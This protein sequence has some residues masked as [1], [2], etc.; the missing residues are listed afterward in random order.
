VAGISPRLEFNDEYR[1]FLDLAAGNVAAAVADARAYDEE[2]S[3]AE[4]LI[5]LDRAKT[6]FF[7]NVSH[8]FRTPLTLVLGPVE[9][10][11]GD[12]AEPAT[13]RQR[14]R[15][16]IAQRNALRLQKLVNTLLDFSRIEAG[17]LQACYEPTDLASLTADL[18]SNFRSACDKA[19]LWLYV[20]CPHLTEPVY[21]DPDL[22]EKIVLNLLSNAFKFTFAGGIDVGLRQER[23]RCVLTVRDTGGGI[24]PDQTPFLFERFHRVAGVKGRTQEGTGIGLALVKELVRLHG[25]EVRAES[26]YGRGSVFTVSVPLGRAHL[27][28]ERIGT[29]SALTSTAL[30]AAPFVEEALRWLPNR[31][32]GDAPVV[33]LHFGLTDGTHASLSLQQKETGASRRPRILLVEDNADMRDY[34]ARLLAGRYEVEATWDGT[35]ALEVALKRPPDLILSDVM[36]PGLDGFGLLRAVRS[37]SRTAETPFLLLS[38]RAGEE[39]RVEGLEAGA[40]DYLTK[41]FS[42]RELLARVGSQLEL[43]KLR[44]EATAALRASEQRTR[45]VLESINDGFLAVDREWRFTYLNPQAER[46]FDK[47]PGELLGK[48]L[49]EVFPPLIGTEFE[50][51]YRRTAS[52][53]VTLSVT[54]FYP[55]HDRWYEVHFY[56]AADGVSVYFRDVNERKRAEEKLSEAERRWRTLAEALPNLVWSALPDGRGGYFSGQCHEYTGYTEAELLGSAWLEKVIHPEDQ[57]R[58]LACWMAALEGKGEYDIEYR[59]RRHDGVYRWFKT[60]GVPVRDEQGRIVR[61]IGTCTDIEDQ[62]RSVERLSE[63][64]ER[65]RQLA[66]AMPQMVWSARP[67]GSIDY[68]NRK[69]QEFT[70]FPP[71]QADDGWRS[72]THEAELVRAR[73]RWAASIATGVPF[74]MEMRLLDRRTGSYRWHLIR[75][76]GVCDAEGKVTRWFGTSTDIHEQKRAEESSRF[77]AEASASLAGVVDYESTLKK[78]VNLAVPYFADWSAVDVANEDGSLRR[79]AVAHQDPEK[80][81]LLHELMR[82]YPPDPQAAS[83]V[84]AVVRTGIPQIVGEITDDM[85]VRGARDERHLQLIRSLGLRSFVC[86]PLVVSGKAIGAL[87][88][89]T[90]ESERVYTDNDIKLALD[91]AHRAAVAIENTQLYQALRDADRRKDEFLATLAHE[92]RN[93][94]APIRNSLQILKMPRVDAG[95]VERSR[96]MMERQVHQ[97]VR[98]VDD[99]LD[100][101]RVMRG[102]IELRKERVELSTV[103]ARAVETVQPLLE[104]QGHELTVDLPA[105]SLA[106]DADLMRLA[107]VVG[108]L[109]TNAAKYTEPGGTIRV[110]ARRDGGA[111]VLS[112]RDT[113]IGIAPDML[114]R[115]FDLFVQVDHAATRSQGGL[116]IGLTLVKNLVEMHKGSVEA[117]SAGL[118]AGSEFVV[119]LPLAAQ[120]VVEPTNGEGRKLLVVDDNQDAAESLATLLRLLGYE[121]VVAHDG[122]SALEV[123][124]TF[125]PEIVFLDIGMPGMDGYE[126]ARRLRGAPG[127]ET[128]RLAALTG[129]GQQADR[130]RTAEAGFDHHLVKPLEPEGLERVLAELATEGQGRH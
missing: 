19:G 98:L 37:D 46:L 120:E 75:T 57:E 41:P 106:L 110:A 9:D 23:G 55:D 28:T 56:P 103:V 86:V 101:S 121:V 31:E 76:V 7:S 25:G 21:V 43:A 129:W 30:G 109:L 91:L 100:V 6:D 50:Q 8:E 88:F 3:R 77:L 104:G 92:L 61:W 44:R 116:G 99:L 24:P 96:E 38:A 27:P 119:R 67:D 122:F 4:A 72:V 105:E 83:G 87:T 66:D 32:P 14:E 108:N 85:L 102:K 22:W 89:A 70:G 60:R 26:E 36:M 35:N 40:D 115:I 113:G 68:L 126:V 90:A 93:P 117:Y 29:E 112:V 118:G 52:E 73:E 65:F 71:D 39:A 107:Q 5:E 33:D 1:R 10:L 42:A 17:R 80:I 74:E 45:I 81:K 64:E 49:W 51:A 15:L 18:A 54:A 94:L 114:P 97:L 82:L 47:K 48:N 111:A 130:R 128:V 16:A 125:L 59:I 58:T 79:L 78:V 95:T 63:S 53:G 2:R 69:W 13:T 124:K 20:D 11:L 12:E 123:V 62:R 127:L 84:Y 34:V